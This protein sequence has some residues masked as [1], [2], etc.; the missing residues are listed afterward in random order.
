MG[1]LGCYSNPEVQERLRQL[2]DKL[3]RLAASDVAPRPSARRDRRLR[4]GLVP[5]AIERVL[6]DSGKPMR[7]REIHAEVEELLG[8]SVPSS[9]VKN[10]LAKQVQD[11][12]PQVVRLGRGRYR[13]VV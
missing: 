11:Q 9:S 12:K 6:A 3:D 13:L 1:L 7:P 10:W 8:K 5:K 4:G 2:S